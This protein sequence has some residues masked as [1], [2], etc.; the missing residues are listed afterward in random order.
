MQNE[1]KMA[2]LLMTLQAGA[3]SKW[4]TACS[5]LS[6]ADKGALLASSDFTTDQ[7]TLTRRAARTTYK[8]QPTS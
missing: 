2:G 6:L 5:A 7:R 8:Q 3:F 4:A 1:T